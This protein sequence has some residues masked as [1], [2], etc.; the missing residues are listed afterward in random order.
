MY[1]LLSIAR[2]SEAHIP[3]PSGEIK[4]SSIGF[5]VPSLVF[6]LLCWIAYGHSLRQVKDII[7]ISESFAAA[8][9]IGEHLLKVALVWFSRQAGGPGTYSM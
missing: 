2:R 5:F 6:S 3:S 7:I 1:A 8:E 9:K 4:C